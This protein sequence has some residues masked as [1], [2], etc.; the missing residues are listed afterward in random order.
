MRYLLF[1]WVAPVGL[2]W[3]WYYLSYYDINFGSIYLSRRLH[4]L[5]FELYGNMLGVDPAS[6]PG[7]IGH[8]FLLDS[9]MIGA[10]VAFRRRRA[11]L[12]WIE[13]VRARRADDALPQSR[14]AE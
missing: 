5:V 9:L 4:D 12:T 8:A 11:I 3:G 6:I 13:A 7:M 2:F 14:P 1:F 10:I